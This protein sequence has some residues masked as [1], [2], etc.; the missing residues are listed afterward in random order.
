MAS[1][2]KMQFELPANRKPKECTCK[3]KLLLLNCVRWT[4][5]ALKIIISYYQ[6]GNNKTVVWSAACPISDLF[7]KGERYWA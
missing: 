5:S 4:G 1:E 3:L 2:L 7:G 6:G